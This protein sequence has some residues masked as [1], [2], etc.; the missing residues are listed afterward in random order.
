[1]CVCFSSLARRHTVAPPR[2]A[3]S[4]GRADPTPG[5]TTFYTLEWSELADKTIS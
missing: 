5:F 4:V 2:R 1:M 3:R